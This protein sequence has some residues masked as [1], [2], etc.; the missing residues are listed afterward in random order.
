MGPHESI[1]DFITELPRTSGKIPRLST[2]NENILPACVKERYDAARDLTVFLTSDVIDTAYV[3]DVDDGMSGPTLASPTAPVVPVSYTSRTY[4]HPCM[5]GAIIDHD[6]WLLQPNFDPEG[7][8]KT[9]TKLQ[10]VRGN[11]MRAWYKQIRAEAMD[12]GLYLPPYEFFHDKHRPTF[13]PVEVTW[14]TCYQVTAV[15]WLLDGMPV[16]QLSFEKLKLCLI[17]IQQRKPSSLWTM[18]SR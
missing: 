7:F 16:L 9:A 11:L 2:W 3:Y 4:F 6:G 1:S 12:H 15:V 8:L 5:S 17:L 13:S 18:V 10:D 14:T